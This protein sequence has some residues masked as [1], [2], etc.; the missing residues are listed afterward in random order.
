MSGVNAFRTFVY[1]LPGGLYEE[2]S[3]AAFCR[4]C[5]I[6]SCVNSRTSF[7]FCRVPA[8]TVRPEMAGAAL[9]SGTSKITRTPGPS[10]AT[11]Y[12]ETSFPPAASIS[13]LA[14]SWRL[15]VGFSKM[16]LR[17]RGVYC[18]VRQNAW[19]V[20]LCG[21]RYSCRFRASGHSVASEMMKVQCLPAVGIKAVNDYRDFG[22]SGWRLFLRIH[23]L[24]SVRK[25]I[26]TFTSCG[27]GPHFSSQE[28]PVQSS[29]FG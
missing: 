25:R 5:L 23:Y 11:L 13:L 4:T 26:R 1:Q 8:V 17:A 14:A 22:T 29:D 21:T 24:S 7:T 27:A 28:I 12:I 16:A 10:E 2:R 20:L 18:P 6:S 19:Y 9:G 3:F 15:V